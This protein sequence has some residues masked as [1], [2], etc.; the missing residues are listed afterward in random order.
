MYVRRSHVTQAHAQSPSF[1]LEF[2][3]NIKNLLGFSQWS[4]FYSL[5]LC[6]A[7]AEQ[8]GWGN[9]YIERDTHH[10]LHLLHVCLNHWSQYWQTKA[11][12]ETP[13][14]DLEPSTK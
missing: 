5:D 1:K 6:S 13:A 11:C 4:E 12:R 10:D 14:L 9:T 2:G 8:V 7:P 3:L